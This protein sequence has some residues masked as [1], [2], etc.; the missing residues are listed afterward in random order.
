[1]AENPTELTT[2]QL[3][4]GLGKVVMGLGG[5]IDSLGEKMDAIFG[6]L[7]DDIAPALKSTSTEREGES[8]AMEIAP[9]LEKLDELKKVLE[10]S[11]SDQPAGSAENSS[12]LAEKLAAIE[13]VLSGEILPAIKEMKVGGESSQMDLSPIIEKL[14]SVTEAIGNIKDPE[15]LK[16]HLDKLSK[17]LEKL[18][19]LMTDKLKELRD[20]DSS[21]PMEAVEQ[22]LGEVCDNLENIQKNL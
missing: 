19:A 20:S 2:E 18:P 12:V 6:V 11:S 10:G 7:S 5:K 21:N 3:L 4:I 15:E 14:D 13:T 1:M 9:L 8:P 22:K 16:P 17:S